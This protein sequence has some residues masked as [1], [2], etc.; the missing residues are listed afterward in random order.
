[1]WMNWN[2][3]AEIKNGWHLAQNDHESMHAH[4]KDDKD[5]GEN[6]K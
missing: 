3:I 1:M 2:V 4:D 6:T 5:D